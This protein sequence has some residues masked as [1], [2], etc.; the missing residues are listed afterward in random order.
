MVN[1]LIGI[2]KRNLTVK[3][4][5]IAIILVDPIIKGV[6]GGLASSSRT[7]GSESWGLVRLVTTSKDVGDALL[8][9]GRVSRFFCIRVNY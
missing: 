9:N 3:A 6:D 7:I 8:S 4:V 1:I 5:L 2:A